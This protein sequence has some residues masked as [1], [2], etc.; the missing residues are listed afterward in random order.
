MDVNLGSYLYCRGIPYSFPSNIFVI[1]VLA[2]LATGKHSPGKWKLTLAFSVDVILLG[3]LFIYISC[4]HSQ[5][6][7]IVS[8][9]RIVYGCISNAVSSGPY[10]H[11]CIIEVL[12]TG[13]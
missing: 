6:C 7:F 8:K 4:T 3:A 1:L 5:E 11:T 13:V 12:G 10:P 2:R 9:G